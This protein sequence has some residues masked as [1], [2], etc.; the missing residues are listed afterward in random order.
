MK[1]NQIANITVVIL[2]LASLFFAVIWIGGIPFKYE[3]EPITYILGLVSV[4]VTGLLKWYSNELEK[5]TFS[6][7]NVLANGY[8]NNFL[9]PVLTQLIKNS[10][11]EAK[12]MFYIFIPELLTDMTGKSIDRLKAKLKAKGL[13]Q[14]TVQIKLGEGR[15]VRDV[16]TISNSKTKNVYFDFPNTIYALTD[17]VDFKLNSPK[18]TLNVKKRNELGKKYIDRFKQQLIETLTERKL[19]PEYIKCADCEFNIEL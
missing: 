9:E 17:Y 4:A 5:E 13:V 3:A 12:P 6:V 19:Y 8:V 15:G 10:G 16:M 7:A 11:T 14:N 2:W 18:D 1:I